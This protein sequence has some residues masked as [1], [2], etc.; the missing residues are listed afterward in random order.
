MIVVVVRDVIDIC[1]AR[2]ADVDVPEIA[3]AR[4]IP[5]IERFS[6]SQ[7]TPS[8][9]SAEAPAETEA[10]SPARAAKPSH[11][12]RSIPRPHPIR[13]RGPSPEAAPINPAAVVEGSESP[14]ISIY[15]GPSPGIFPNPVSCAVWAPARRDSIRL[16]NL[17]VIRSVVP[18]SVVVQVLASHGTGSHVS[19]RGGIIFVLIA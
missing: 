14:R 4:A 7:R 15:P 8:E 12:R 17:S 5:R 11:Q 6:P 2:I 1:N 18:G 9:A 16:P 10:K 3:P 19:G 13:S